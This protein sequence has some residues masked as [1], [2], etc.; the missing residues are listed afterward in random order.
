MLLLAGTQILCGNVHDAV[1]VD[2]ECDLDLRDAARRRRDAVELEQAELLVVAREFT[3]A[4]QHVDLHLGL[5][6]RGGGEDLALLGRDGGVAVNDLGHDAAHGFHAQR[7]RGDIQQQQALNLAAE[8]AGLNRGADCDALV[9]VDALERL[10]A[11]KVLDRILH[12]GDPRGAADHQH[13]A[14]LGDL[15]PGILQGLAHRA[16]R[17]FDEVGGQ[18]VEFRPRKGQVKVFRAARVR[19]DKRQVDGR[20]G[21]AG[22]LDFRFFGGFLQALHR[23]FVAG[24]VDPVFLFEVLDHPVDDALVKIVAAQAVVAGGREDLLHAVAHLDDGDVER[25]AAQIVN[26]HFLVFALVYAVGKRGGC[27]L[28]DDALD[29]EA[30]DLSGVLRRLAL[31]VREVGGH[32][33]DGGV[34]R[35]AQIRFGVPLQLLQNHRRD[36][37]RRKAL[38]VN[39]HFIVGAHFPFDGGNGALR[40]RD[41][42][43]LCDL[44]DHPFAGFGE[45][46]DGRRGP[47]AFGIRNDNGFAALDDGDTGVGCT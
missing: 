28:V 20:G 29:V 43:T 3:L 47:C 26:H 31:G 42:L 24:K 23:H 6:V 44:A 13:L 5:A 17:L 33:D 25:A 10:L 19:G 40:V 21:H 41:R 27:R 14:D 15:K 8:N 32:R 9:G 37:L 2:I 18:L 30:G 45:S 22:K 16:H 39:V 35:L 12:G 1:R 7:K 36:F 11:D 4:L 46:D 38:S 34:D